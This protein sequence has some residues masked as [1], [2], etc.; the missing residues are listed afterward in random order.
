MKFEN[1]DKKYVDE[2]LKIALQ[3]YKAECLKCGSELIEANFEDHLR[4]ML[5]AL[6]ER[7]IGKVALENGRVIGYMAFWGPM[8]EFL[9]KAKGVFSPLGG[10][11]FSGEDRNKLASRLFQEVSENL[12]N[13]HVT[14]Y[15]LC[16]YAHDE[17][18]GR[19][20][21]MNG[22]GIRGSEAMMKL[23]QRKHMEALVP[24]ITYKELLGEEKERVEPLDRGLI[25]HMAHSP[26]FFPTDLEDFKE[27]L[28]QSSARVFA[29]IDQGEVIGMM[30]VEVEGENFITGNDKVYCI[31]ETFL[32]EAYRGKKVADGLLEYVCQTAEGEGITYLS[33]ECETLN[34]TARRFWEKHF[35]NYTYSYARRID[36]RSIGFDSY[37]KAFFG[38]KEEK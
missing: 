1:V 9:G 24:S 28:T 36:E 38:E 17:E 23:S 32:K 18:L 29:A 5:E 27:N 31:C 33:V 34:P 6:F 7:Q 25:Y 22:F 8:E 35:T 19:S 2:A 30:K 37:M 13:E 16:C 3:E 10:N 11:G 12:L 4:G 26:I 21:V 20:L 14:S 15:A